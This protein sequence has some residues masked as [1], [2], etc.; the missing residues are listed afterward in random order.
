PLHDSNSECAHALAHRNACSFELAQQI[1]SLGEISRRSEKSRKVRES[2]TEVHRRLQYHRRTHTA[3]QELY[4]EEK[5]QRPASR[6]YDPALR[7]ESTGLE[8]NLRRAARE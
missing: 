6:E 5:Q 8:C 7:H 3:T 2:G 1:E 4:S